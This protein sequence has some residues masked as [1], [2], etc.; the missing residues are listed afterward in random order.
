MPQES[1]LVLRRRPQ[2]AEAREAPQPEEQG[3]HQAGRGDPLQ[4]PVHEGREEAGEGA[5]V[6]RW[7]P[8]N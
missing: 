2:L 5:V 3:A 7:D 8:V 1:V 4:G 6:H